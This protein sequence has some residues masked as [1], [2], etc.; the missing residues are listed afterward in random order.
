[1]RQFTV[2]SRQGIF[3]AQLVDPNT[4]DRLVPRSTGTKNK[5]DA[6]LV[7]AEWLKS[8]IPT[9]RK[10]KTRPL[11]IA[12]SLEG[13]L[14]SIKKIDINGDDA[15]RIVYALKER[16][17]IDIQAVKSGKGSMPFAK[18][19]ETF[20]DYEKSPYVRE[21]LAHKQTIGKRHCYEMGNRVRKYWIPAFNNR[22]LNSITK[23]DL[24]ELSMSMAEAGLAPAT[25]N[26]TM[27][28]GNV[29]LSW[30]YQ[31]GMIPTD[32][33]DGLLRFSGEPKKRGV[34]TPKEAQQIFH[35]VWKDKR[36]YV[37][38]LLAITTGLRSGE[39]LALKEN[40]VKNAVK[41]LNI[42]HSWSNDDGL[43]S[44]KNGEARKVPLLPT[45]R[46]KLLEIINEN[47]HSG[48]N[49]FIFYGLLNDKPIDGKFLVKALKEAC[50]GA[51][52]DAV[53]RNI[54]FHSHRHYYASRMVDKMTAEQISRITG[55]KSKAVFEE[56]ADHIIEENLE[57]A[58]DVCAEVFGDILPDR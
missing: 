53:E 9:G 34:L 20:W 8:G 19:L 5:K 31:E 41:V 22:A 25:I 58:N 18:L 24:K 37:A 46:E 33:T 44:P 2:F 7:V 57:A 38:S 49:R 17:L 32:P 39:V 29:A 23:A 13:I 56:Y 14:K 26:K 40:D 1:M 36:A 35:T 15:M 27:I 52:I 47:P 12:T 55:H 10:R 43:K 21:K 16:G 11:E 42:N 28:A 4:G 3:Y 54:V 6:M 30:A 50:R 51:G 48:E 45:V